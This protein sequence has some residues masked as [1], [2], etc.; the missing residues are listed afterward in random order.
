MQIF[1]LYIKGQVFSTDFN[2]L[3]NIKFHNNP[4]RDKPADMYGQRDRYDEANS[5]FSPINE[6]NQN[7][8][9]APSHTFTCIPLS[10][11]T[12]V[13]SFRHVLPSISILL[14]LICKQVDNTDT[15]SWCSVVTVVSVINWLNVSTASSLVTREVN[16]VTQ[17]EFG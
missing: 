11:R 2:K 8:L 12:T 9:H 4:F 5:R 7:D 10:D 17:Q 1:L 6:R 13:Q 15:A 14:L 16:F 3:P